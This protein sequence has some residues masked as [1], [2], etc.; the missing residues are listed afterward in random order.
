MAGVQTE[1]TTDT[2]GGLN[3][4]YIDAGD[5]MSY[6]DAK[7]EAP[8][9]GSYK[10]TFRVASLNGGGSMDLR[11]ASSDAVLDTFSV[12]QT[13]GWQV[14]TDVV[15]TVNL[16]K[17]THT[18]KLYAGVGGFNVN[19]FKVEVIPTAMPLTI[20]AENYT[21]MLGVQTEATTDTDGGL[22]VGYI[23]ALDSMSYTNLDVMIVAAGN[24]KVTYRVA[25]LNGGGSFTI[26]EAGSTTVYDTI[27]VPQTGGWQIWT[28]VE[29]IINLPAGKHNF[30][31]NAL[32]GGFNLNWFKLEPWTS[33]TLSSS[34]SAAS[35]TS[36]ATSS[37]ASSSAQSTTST[38][39]STSSVASSAASSAPSYSSSSAAGSTSNHVAGPVALSWIPPVARENGTILDITELGGYELRYRQVTDNTYTYITINDAWTTQ[40]NFTWLEG[41]YIFEVAA[42]DKNG[43]Y[44]NFTNLYPR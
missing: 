38:A 35:S 3:V 22:N 29:R 30:T 19:W 18:F 27:S 41:D 14:W 8:V 43:I 21:S 2:D 33:P 6:T 13:G 37:A 25:S 24:Y 17:G 15:R 26:G 34:S 1:T 7:F 42:F 28:N 10:I 40:Q 11:E 16:T 32:V 23:D 44:S 4:G 36:T 5:W 31:I 39:S 9:T 20:Q 12:P